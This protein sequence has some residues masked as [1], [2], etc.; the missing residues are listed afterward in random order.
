VPSSS[1]STIVGWT[2]SFIIYILILISGVYILQSHNNKLVKYTAS[3]KNLL[4]VTLVE[5]KE[6][7]VQKKKKVKVVKKKK[8]ISKPK[9]APKKKTVRAKK[10]TTKSKPDFKKL[11]GKIDLDKLPKEKAKREK[12][13]RK[14]IVQ[15]EIEEV[16]KEEKAKKITKTLEFEKQESLIVSQNSGVYD[17]FIGKVRDLLN[18]KWDETVGEFPGVKATVIIGIDKFGNFSYKI[19]RLSYNDAFNARLRNFLENMRLEKFPPSIEKDKFVFKTD[20][21]DLQND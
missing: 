19:D 21:G 2:L 4:T 6:K 14:K 16:V 7:R 17:K 18:L 15:K 8:T 11:F 12:K 13:I 1:T 20:I 5:K 10:T 9:T 3:K